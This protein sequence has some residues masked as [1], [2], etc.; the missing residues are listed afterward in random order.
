MS[1]EPIKVMLWDFFFFFSLSK[2]KEVLVLWT[3]EWEA[4]L[5]K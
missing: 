5:Q 1:T 4:G 3:T 2:Q